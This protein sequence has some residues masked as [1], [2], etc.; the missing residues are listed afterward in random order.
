MLPLALSVTMG[1]GKFS[2]DWELSRGYSTVFDTVLEWVRDYVYDE[3]G[4]I[5]SLLN[6]VQSIDASHK[7]DAINEAFDYEIESSKESCMHVDESYINSIRRQI[8]AR[9]H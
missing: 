9:M 5:E 6:K 3:T 8:M 4:D 1:F 7:E 2:N